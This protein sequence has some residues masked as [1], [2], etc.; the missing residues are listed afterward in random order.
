MRERPL[1]PHASVYRIFR[2]TLLTS[3][4]NRLTGVALTFGFLL[5]V[6]WLVALSQGRAAYERAVEIL[7]QGWWLIIWLGLLFSFVYH[8]LGGI[9]H[10]IWDTGRG[11]EREQSKKSAWFLGAITAVLVFALGYVLIER[12]LQ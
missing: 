10:L 3:F 2:Y 8:L 12:F 11:L 7:S 9:R 4:L 5:L 1:S 6:Y